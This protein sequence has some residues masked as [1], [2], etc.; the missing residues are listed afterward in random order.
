MHDPLRG[1]SCMLRRLL[2]NPR[3]LSPPPPGFSDTTM[4][5]LRGAAIAKP[6]ADMCFCDF[7]AAALSVLQRYDQSYGM[8]VTYRYQ[9]GEMRP[10]TR[11]YNTH[12][13][14]ATNRIAFVFRDMNAPPLLMGVDRS[15][16]D[17]FQT[18]LQARVFEPGEELSSAHIDEIGD[19][20]FISEG[21]IHLEGFRFAC[22]A[23]QLPATPNHTWSMGAGQIFGALPWLLERHE[24]T[25][26]VQ[27]KLRYRAVAL[28]QVHLFVLAGSDFIRWLRSYPKIAAQM[29]H[30]AL[31]E[32]HLLPSSA[33]YF[34]A[35]RSML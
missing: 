34:A 24:N 17:S 3:L 5:I 30:N 6:P 7:C 4:C 25:A 26:P 14:V 19:I 22:Y 27:W 2:R 10:A 9:L 15:I 20:C 33:E 8:M 16:F 29:Q 1:V 13:I 21:R 32:L 11:A 31:N 18:M 35:S 23:R 12:S 28:T